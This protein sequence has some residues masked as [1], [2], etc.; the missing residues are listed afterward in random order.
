MVSMSVSVSVSVSLSAVGVLLD[1]K[2]GLEVQ[3]HTATMHA[4][5]H[6]HAHTHDSACMQACQTLHMR[7]MFDQVLNSCC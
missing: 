7:T 1:Q 6:I 4:V 5:R 2:Q 3:P